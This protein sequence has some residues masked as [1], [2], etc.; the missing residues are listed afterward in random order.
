M[1]ATDQANALFSARSPGA[2]GRIRT[3]DARFR[4]PTLYPL[5]YGSG[6]GK[7][8]ADDPSADLRPDATVP[9]LLLDELGVGVE[10]EPGVGAALAVEVAGDPVTGEA[11]QRPL[12][13]GELHRAVGALD[14]REHVAVQPGGQLGTVHDD[15]RPG[16]RAAAL[17]RRRAVLVVRECVHRDAVDV[18]H[19]VTE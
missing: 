5:S 4:K 14:H 1:E 17:A 19:H 6:L 8:T 16:V 10:D 7:P 9:R 13:G 11:V 18:D 2:P 15:R 3:C 12:A